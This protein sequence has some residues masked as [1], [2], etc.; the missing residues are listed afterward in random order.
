M[1]RH[2]PPFTR[3]PPVRGLKKEGAFGISPS[4]QGG[5]LPAAPNHVA[6]RCSACGE[7]PK[8]LKKPPR[9]CPNDLFGPRSGSEA[10]RVRAFQGF[11]SCA[12]PRMSWGSTCDLN[13]ANTGPGCHIHRVMCVR[14]FRVPR[15]DL[16]SGGTLQH[17]VPPQ[18]Q[19]CPR[20]LQAAGTR[21]GIHPPSIPATG[22]RSSGGGPSPDGEDAPLLPRPQSN[23]DIRPVS[24]R[25]TVGEG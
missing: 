9:L 19:G 15:G 25:V 17:T 14:P 20:V 7:H 1:N 3:Q 18:H 22:C 10:A 8:R 21:S 12:S 13:W 5:Q 24:A 23:G 6:L 11:K 16:L 2:A 4:L